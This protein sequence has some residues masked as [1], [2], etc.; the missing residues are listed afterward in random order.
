MKNSILSQIT[1]VEA[2]SAKELLCQWHKYFDHPPQSKNNRN[3]LSAQIIYRIQEISLGGLSSETRQRL[4]EHAEDKQIVN[5]KAR[6]AVGTR[7]V[8]EVKGIEHQVIVLPDG[9]DYNGKKYKSLSGVAFAITGT[10]WNGNRFF[11][12]GE[13]A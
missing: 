9:F 12:V 7:L 11:G 6:L 5:S 13:K 10:R 1:A 4:I 3:Y 2:M 8:R